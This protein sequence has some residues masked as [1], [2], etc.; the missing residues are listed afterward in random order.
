[1]YVNTKYVK[2]SI[3]KT[4]LQVY[5]VNLTSIF[6]LLLDEQF[7]MDQLTFNLTVFVADREFY[8]VFPKINVNRQIGSLFFSE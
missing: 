5:G 3:Y 2:K 8:F 7:N 4:S 6:F 1:M